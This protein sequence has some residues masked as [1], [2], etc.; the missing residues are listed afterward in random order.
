VHVF[1]VPMSA[2]WSRDDVDPGLSDE[3]RTARF[4]RPGHYRKFGRQDFR[5]EA[6]KLNHLLGTQMID[7]KKFIPK[8]LQ[9]AAHTSGNV[10]ALTPRQ[11][12]GYM[13]DAVHIK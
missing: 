5:N 1:S 13:P 12:V 10:F 3:E 6:Q 8:E 7:A 11:P 4:G 9:Y 2:E